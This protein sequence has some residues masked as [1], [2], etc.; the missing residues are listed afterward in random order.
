M[1]IEKEHN[2]CNSAIFVS[3]YLSEGPI[4]F[5]LALNQTDQS[6]LEIIREAYI[7]C[8]IIGD[9]SSGMEMPLLNGKKMLDGKS[10]VYICKNYTCKKPI[11]N[12]NDLKLALTS[13]Q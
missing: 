7:P 13:I 4:E 3:K 5:A 1:F 9:S 10:T 2:T 8:K 6:L 12:G 11:T